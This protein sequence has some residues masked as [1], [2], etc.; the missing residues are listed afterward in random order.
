[1]GI[2]K[3]DVRLVAHWTLPPTP[4]AY[5]QE[6]GRAG[7]DGAPATC[8][9]LHRAGDAELHRRQLDVTFPPRVLAEAVWADPRRGAQV[10]SNTLASIARLRRELE[11]ERGPVDWSRVL[12][13]RHAALERIDAMARYATG[14]GCRRSTLLAWFGE[15]APRCGRCDRCEASLFDRVRH[16][17]RR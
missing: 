2:D 1:M 4:E 3:P 15:P 7:R 13:R 16:W 6:A 10:A 8:L 11:P 9:L 5:Y 14:L 17:L 12:R